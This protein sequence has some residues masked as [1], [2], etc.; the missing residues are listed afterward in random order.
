MNLEPL[1][2]AWWRRRHPQQPFPFDEPIDARRLPRYLVDRVAATVTRRRNPD[3][4]WITRDAI[5]LLDSLLGP[6]DIG[7]EYGS[8]GS[9]VWF[10]GRTAKVTA[11]EA[12]PVWASY[13]RNRLEAAGVG[14]AELLVVEGE[15]GSDEHRAAYVGAKPELE[16]QSLDYVFVDGEYRSSGML[17]AMDL[18]K[19]GGLL[20]LDNSN[21]YLPYPTRCPLR[22]RKPASEEW[23]TVA[24]LLEP[25]RLV[26]TTN[27]AWDTA[28]WFKPGR[29]AP[30]LG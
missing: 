5:R 1:A 10:A 3:E 17:R 20:I 22:V 13:T 15:R 18:L 21:H 14:N 4:P 11:V 9:T 23:A 2:V 29:E 12:Y 30:A 19:P 7:F 24:R 27:G 26:W 28:V 8:G 16:P 6:D 25:W